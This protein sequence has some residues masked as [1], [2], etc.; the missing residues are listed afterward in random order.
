M[1]T[2]QKKFS[3]MPTVG[4]NIRVKLHNPMAA[5]MIPPQPEFR[6]YQG[7]VLD[8]WRWLTD[9]EFCMEGDRDWPVR[10]ININSVAEIQVLS[11]TL[12]EIDI[13]T[14]TWSVEGSRG[15]KY[16]VQRDHRGWSCSCPGF[17]FRRQCRHI[18]ELSEK[19]AKVA[20]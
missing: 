6:E 3:K 1:N 17:Q 2:H 4:S 13:G 15:N 18:V 12:T 20:T 16:Q 10:V 11:G 9:R 19:H 14:K 8:S 7:R 5:R